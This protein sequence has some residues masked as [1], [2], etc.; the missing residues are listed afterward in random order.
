MISCRHYLSNVEIASLKREQKQMNTT[1]SNLQKQLKQVEAQTKKL[2]GEKK[3][4][5]QERIQELNEKIDQFKSVKLAT[6]EAQAN[7]E[8][9]KVDYMSLQ[10]YR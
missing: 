7:N 10:K 8:K 1:I 6:E 5:Q 2:S 9:R 4:E 3:E